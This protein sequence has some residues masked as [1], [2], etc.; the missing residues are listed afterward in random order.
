MHPDRRGR[1]GPRRRGGERL[2]RPPSDRD[3]IA[4]DAEEYRLLQA[5]EVLEAFY[6]VGADD[7]KARAEAAAGPSADGGPDDGPSND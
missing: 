6:A 2:A 1:A 5:E 3:R 4:A 7:E